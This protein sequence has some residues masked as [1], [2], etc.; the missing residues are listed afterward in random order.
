M[1]GEEAQYTLTRKTRPKEVIAIYKYYIIL[2][3]IYIY[4]YIY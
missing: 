1:L 2:H 3:Y 4:I